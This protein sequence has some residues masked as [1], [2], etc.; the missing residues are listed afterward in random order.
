MERPVISS[1]RLELAI[2][3]RQGRHQ[4]DDVA[5]GADHGAEPAGPRA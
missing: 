5:K 1:S 3:N 4:N 2:F